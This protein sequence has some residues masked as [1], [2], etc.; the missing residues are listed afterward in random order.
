MDDSNIKQNYSLRILRVH[1]KS[2]AG[3]KI[4][5]MNS[6]MLDRSDCSYFCVSTG[7]NQDKAAGPWVA[8]A[9]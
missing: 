7:C 9:H 2:G 5:S 4:H 3:N 1:I 8:A 6:C